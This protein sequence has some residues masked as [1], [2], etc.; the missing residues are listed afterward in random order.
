MLR[1]L[2]R[3]PRFY[4][5]FSRLFNVD[6]VHRQLVQETG[7]RPG[8][9]TLDIGC[10]PGE[11]AKYIAPADF[12]G[13]DISQEYI[14]FARAQHGG[15]FHALPADRVGE[16]AGPFDLALMFGVFHHLSDAEVRA[17][18]AGLARV[19]R[20]TGRFVLWEAVWP[21]RCWDL[22]GYLLRWL[23]RGRFVR[24]RAAWCRLLG[25]TWAVTDVRVRRNLVIEYFICTL[26][27]PLPAGRTSEASH[28]A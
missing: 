3:L 12:T 28:A 24:S 27:P 15:A 13:I 18:L 23:D 5:S 21:S 6:A 2:L 25:E 1:I 8:M 14:R 20:P 4:R 9:R 10:G 7:Y 11:L 17:T 22:P 16:L 26:T 19:L